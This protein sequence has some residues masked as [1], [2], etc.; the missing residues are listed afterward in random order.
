MLF[1]Y[2]PDEHA[3]LRLAKQTR[4]TEPLKTDMLSEFM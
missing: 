3:E 2:R 1:A 4:S